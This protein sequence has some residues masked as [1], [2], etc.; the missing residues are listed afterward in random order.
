[1]QSQDTENVAI[2]MK[3]RIVGT[4]VHS[5][6]QRGYSFIET[7]ALFNPL[8][9][10][11]PVSVFGHRSKIDPEYPNYFSRGQFVEFNVVRGDK[12]LNAVGIQP[13]DPLIIGEELD[14]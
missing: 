10:E 4:V 11:D 13:F 5:D 8:F 12:G 6:D 1:M 7:T 14:A 9:P 2:D 3:A